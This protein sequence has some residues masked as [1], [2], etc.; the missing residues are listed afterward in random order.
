[1]KTLLEKNEFRK[2]ISLLNKCC[3][4]F[5]MPKSELDETFVTPY[6]TDTL[7]KYNIE[8]YL[9]VSE[10]I[11]ENKTY[12]AS[13]IPNLNNMDAFI[14]LLRNSKTNTIVS[15]IPDN[16]HLKNYNCISSEKIFYD[17]QALFF[18][19]RYDF[20]G[21]EVRIFRF[22]NWIDHSTITKDQIE[23]FYQYI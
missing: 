10:I 3:F 23:T 9:N 17:N 6:S 16:D 19:E 5:M 7:E 22:V 18:D 4:K 8:S 12:L 14:E 13:Q 1:I 21:Y 11:F 15:L 2:A 20:K